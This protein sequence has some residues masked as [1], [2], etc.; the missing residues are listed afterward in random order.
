[1]HNIHRFR[2]HRERG[3]SAVLLALLSGPIA[4][5]PVSAEPW[6]LI[7][8]GIDVTP[9]DINN[10][11]TIV[12]LRA[13]QSGN[14]GFIR[15][16]GG[17]AADIPGTQSANAVNANGHVTG[18]TLTGAFL[19]DGTLHEWD[20]YGG[21][22]INGTGQIAGNALL[23]NP[24][25][26]APLPFDAAIYTPDAWASAGVATVY[27]RGT[28]PGAYADLYQLEDINDAG[29]AVGSHRRSGLTGASAILVTPDFDTVHFLPLPNG[30]R[31]A[32][33]NGQN[34]VVG[35]TGSNAGSGAYSHAYLYDYN[36]GNLV[37]L[38]T[39]NGGLTSSAADINE[40]N[41][42]VGTSW[43]VDRLTSRHDPA[44]Y[45]AFLWESG[46]L[47]DLNDLVPEDSGWI[48]TAATAIN[49]SGGIVGTGLHDGQVHGF[50]LSAAP[51]RAAAPAQAPQAVAGADTSSGRVALTVNFSAAGSS[52]PDGE[53]ARYDWD[54]GDGS[55]RVQ[56]AD[57]THVYTEPGTYLAMLTVTDTQGLSDAAQ[58]EIRAHK[59][60]DNWRR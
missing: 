57:P 32:A 49:D 36:S 31:A 55:V 6:Q 59:W 4:A 44:Q 56:D 52:D 43:L 46:T 3:S 9:A 37:D 24:Y 50:L 53:I 41:Q 23:P 5:L 21:Y 10:Q 15:S 12:G 7:D 2:Q 34:M 47:T 35:E 30:G 22:G 11:G 26:L 14:I 20:G 8:L 48:L 19:Y 60:Q 54:F 45:H 29:F 1:M 28:R 58:L 18:T 13:T 16:A 40:Q 38:G 27:A 39:L 51:A 42:V 17:P 25:R 33:I